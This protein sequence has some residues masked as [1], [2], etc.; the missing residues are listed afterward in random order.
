M[1]FFIVVINVEKF[2]IFFWVMLFSLVIKLIK[3]WCL[4][5]VLFGLNVGVIIVLKF[6]LV[7]NFLCYLR[8]LRGWFVV[9][10]NIILLF[11]IKCLG[12]ILCFFKKWFKWW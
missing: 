7:V 1:C 6:L 5:K 12:F 8:V 3:C 9:L 2:V 11:V 4:I 10:I